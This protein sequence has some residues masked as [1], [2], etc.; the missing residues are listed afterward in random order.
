MARIN[1]ALRRL[2]THEGARAAHI[3]VSARLSQQR[4]WSDWLAPGWS[5][6]NSHPK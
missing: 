4:G 5:R 3:S 2:F 1:Q 6:T